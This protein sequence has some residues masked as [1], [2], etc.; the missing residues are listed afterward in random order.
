M[1][2]ER[3]R[4]LD[5]ADPW[6]KGQ[7]ESLRGA[8]LAKW[9]LSLPFLLAWRVAWL[10]MSVRGCSGTPAAPLCAEGC[11]GLSCLSLVLV[12]SCIRARTYYREPLPEVRGRGGKDAVARQIRGKK[13][14]GRKKTRC[15][16]HNSCQEFDRCFTGTRKLPEK[17]HVHNQS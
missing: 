6:W 9:L 14:K 11:L 8:E 4:S 5:P 2:S 15:A 12:L 16:S 1:S 7:L 10:F 17:V 13:K 3:S